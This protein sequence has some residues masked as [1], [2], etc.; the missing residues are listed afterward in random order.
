MINLKNTKLVVLIISLFLILAV[1]PFI[2]L[3]FYYNSVS[4]DYGYASL[5]RDIGFYK[6]QAMWYTTW[7]GR[8]TSSFLISINPVYW[9][10]KAGIILCPL[11][12]IL[13]FCFSVYT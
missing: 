7:T 9:N 1:L 11:L 12:I 13:L 6:S 10:W 2:I 8:Y 3:S 5:M 4:D